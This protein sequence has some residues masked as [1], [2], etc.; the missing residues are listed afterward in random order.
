M[1]A[2]DALAVVVVAHDSERSLPGLLR[3]LAQQLEP[4][5]EVVVVDNASADRTAQLIR[6]AGAPVRLVES[7]TNLGF[8]AGCHLGARATQA[9]LLLFLNPDCRPQDGCLEQLRAAAGQQPQWGAWQAAVMLPDGHINTDGGVVHYVGIGWSG[10][11]GRAA[12]ALPPSARDVAFAS[13]AAL[14]IR[15]PVWEELGGLDPS[16]FLYS[17]DLDLGLR[18]WLAGY[19]VGVVPGARVVHDYE[20]EKGVQK[21]FWLER[22]RWR[23]VL[24][25][26]PARLL[27]LVLPAML[28]VELAVMAAAGRHGWLR[29]KLRAQLAVV[30]DL[31]ATFAR[32]RR[33][34]ASRRVDPRQ[35]AGRLTAALDSPFLPVIPAPAAVALQRRYWELVKRL[36]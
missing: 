14:T 7:A 26:Y 4:A 29:A 5:D 25:V 8:G 16:Y 3:A 35:F 15:R 32:R 19:G 1:S 28:S 23:T 34:Q 17:E 2:P 22:N 30:S 21:W 18:L 6:E 20:F 10:D 12:E 24:S 11:C 13:G 36:L 9:P 27:M 31:P 33:V